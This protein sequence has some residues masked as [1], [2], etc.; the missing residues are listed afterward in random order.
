MGH[1]EEKCYDVCLIIGH[2]IATIILMFGNTV[3]SCTDYFSRT[4]FT[5]APTSAKRFS[6]ALPLA[7]VHRPGLRDHQIS[8]LITCHRST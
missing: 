1:F 5:L 2:Y 7:V 8:P 4:T 3:R 6:L